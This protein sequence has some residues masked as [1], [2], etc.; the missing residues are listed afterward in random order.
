MAMGLNMADGLQGMLKDGHKHFEGIDEAV[1]KNI[2]A[3]HQLSAITRTSLGPT[4]MNKLV[5]NHLEKITVTSDTA[6]IVTELEVMHPAAKVL[7]LAAQMQEQEVG[8]GTNLAVTFGGEMMHQSTDLLRMGL[9]TSEVIEGYKKAAQKAFEILENQ[10]CLY[11]LPDV[12]NEAELTR[13]ISS[14]LAAKQYGYENILAPFVAKA[15]LTVMG[16]KRPNINTESVRVTKI[17]GGSIHQSEVIRGIVVERNVEGTVTEAKGAKI[18]VFS[19]GIETSG[20]EAKG[21]VLIKTAGELMNYNK[22]EEQLME[23]SIKAISEAGVKVIVA[24]GSIS[25]MALHFIER[26]GMMVLKIMSKFELRRVCRATKSVALVRLGPP[27]P[28]EIG[29]CESVVC[30]EIGG[31]KVIIFNQEAESCNVATIVLRAS[32]ENVLS[33]LERAIDDGVNCVKSTCL[34]PRFC[35]GAGATE[36]ELA[37]QLA[38]YA[39]TCPGLEQYAIKKFAECFETIPRAMAENSGQ[40]VEEVISKLYAAHG[41]GNISVGLDLENDSGISDALEAGILDNYAVK[42][43]ALRL[44]I[45]AAMTV[46][47]VDQIIMSKPAGGPKL[48]GR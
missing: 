32:T 1:A 38:I 6:A 33:D 26:Y 2:E 46:L 8:D 25:E 19:C 11:T 40:H 14:V 13:C 9:H 36:I 44:S 30:R 18:A 12:K 5:I 45:D 35:P 10:L 4:G 29:S 41:A 3:I 22:G 43:S 34:D 24:G 17:M 42:E 23:D 16:S 47:S 15:C 21:T 37:R 31:R 39:D 7:V 20:T 48:P 28:E 27:T